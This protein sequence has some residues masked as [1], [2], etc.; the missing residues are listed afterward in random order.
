LSGW[1][2]P[3][4]HRL[5]FPEVVRAVADATGQRVLGVSEWK[6]RQRR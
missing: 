2:T 3:R 5:M 1:L 6:R 4:P